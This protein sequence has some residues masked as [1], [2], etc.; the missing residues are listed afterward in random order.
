MKRG[1]SSE[2]IVCEGSIEALL[3]TDI[4]R[5]SVRAVELRFIPEVGTCLGYVKEFPNV[6]SLLI[7]DANGEGGIKDY[8]QLAELTGLRKLCVRDVANFDTD[9]MRAI[10][11]MPNLA[12]LELRAQR[13][14]RIGDLK[15]LAGMKCLRELCLDV[16]EQSS[17]NLFVDDLAFVTKMNGLEYLDVS[18]LSRIDLSRFDLPKGLK[19]IVVPRYTTKA[20]CARLSR[21]CKVEVAGPECRPNRYRFVREE[22]REKARKETKERAKQN[23]LLAAADGKIRNALRAL[24]T[25]LELK[26]CDAELIAKVKDAVDKAIISSK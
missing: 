19:N 12:R 25:G 6:E 2:K 1:K 18:F 11:S 3:R 20:V 14:A 26:R 5:E 16:N 8:G 23:P 7:M 9:T 24:I 13:I 15:L 10:A 22:D 17:T 4:D 21:Q